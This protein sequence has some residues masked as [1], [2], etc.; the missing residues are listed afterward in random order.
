M[1]DQAALKKLLAANPAFGKGFKIREPQIYMKQG[2]KWVEFNMPR[3]TPR[4]T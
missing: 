4:K 3:A 2:D 1:G